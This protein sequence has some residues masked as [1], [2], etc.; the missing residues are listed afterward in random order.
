MLLS[1]LSLR[2][3]KVGLGVVVILGYIGLMLYVKHL[4]IANTLLK[5]KY[6]QVESH[7]IIQNE[8]IEKLQLDTKAYV[9]EKP[10]I[11]EKIITK[12]QKIN[13]EIKD[14]GC[15]NELNKIKELL[16]AFKSD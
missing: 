16:R 1:F 5:E 9:L 14:L 15:E 11:K 10:K 7:L 13:T 8:T 12:Y 2:G 4:V 3:F 6:K